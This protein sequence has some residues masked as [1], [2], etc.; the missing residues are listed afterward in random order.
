MREVP[1]YIYR[2]DVLGPLGSPYLLSVTHP[3]PIN[4][5]ERLYYHSEISTTAQLI[6]SSFGPGDQAVSPSLVHARGDLVSVREH[7][8]DHLMRGFDNTL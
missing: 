2:I 3:L 8:M 7:G 5:T 4:N 1:T 6:S